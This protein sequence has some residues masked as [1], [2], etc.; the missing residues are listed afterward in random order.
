MK[1]L[2]G[3]IGGTKT[4]L[5]I[6]EVEGT[7]LEMLALEKYPSQEY[8]S[9]NEIVRQF[10]ETQ[11]QHCDWGSFGIAGPV[12]NGRAETTNLPWLIDARQ[13]AEDI[14][15]RK[16]WLMND[17]EANAW[18]ISALEE[19]DFCILSEGK[20]DP[21]GNAS[22]ISAGTGLGQAGLYWNGAQHRPFA[23]EGG[24]SDFAPHSDLE[25]ALLQ[26]LKQR[27]THVSWER[28][29]SGMGIVNIY[30][31]LKD[32]RDVETPAWLAEE[33]KNGDKAA[34]ISKAA[35][36]GRCP[37]CS[38]TLKLFVHLYGVEAGN[39]ALKLMSTAGVYLGGGIVPKN[40]DLFLEGTFLR[41]FR[42]KGRMESLM[43]DIPV[44]VILNDLTALYG[45][46]VFAGSEIKS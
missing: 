25:I 13:L 38:E 20:P 21:N 4:S 40:L 35:N 26:Y 46:A 5:A 19:K 1:V 9:L 45:P 30:D 27:Y 33:I 44:K 17:L 22:I 31:F 28:V 24:H 29:V 39:Q 8:G 41:S 15:F 18:G 12:R 2:A 11:G 16:V 7:K 10:D 37:L 6:F 23:S 14:G 36:E 3:D 34:A 43:N 42:A 32:H